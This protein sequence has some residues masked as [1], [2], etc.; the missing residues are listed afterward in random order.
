[1]FNQ[2]ETVNLDGLKKFIK[3]HLIFLCF[4]LIVYLIDR[5][6]FNFGIGKISNIFWYIYLGGIAVYIG[7]IIIERA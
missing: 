5:R 6:L 4:L 3:P 2:G 1:M 7:Y